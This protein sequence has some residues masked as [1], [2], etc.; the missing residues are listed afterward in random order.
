MACFCFE[1]FRIVTIFYS[2]LLPELMKYVGKYIG[3]D[4]NKDFKFDNCNFRNKLQTGE[5]YF[6]IDYNY[7]NNIFINK[8]LDCKLQLLRL[9][10][11]VKYFLISYVI[12]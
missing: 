2:P 9:F 6:I 3:M 1:F 10:L 12:Y 8:I 11:I 7:K 4:T 5:Q